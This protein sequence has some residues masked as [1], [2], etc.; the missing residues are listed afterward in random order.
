MRLMKVSSLVAEAQAILAQK[1]M[2]DG[3]YYCYRCFDCARLI[4][5]IEVI[6]ARGRGDLALCRCGSRKVKPT[7]PTVW[8][9]LFLPRCWKLI[10]AIHTQKI[11]LM[12]LP[13]S[14]E[15]QTDAERVARA[16]LRAFEEQLLEQAKNV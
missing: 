2:S 10:Y 1:R 12:P 8:E 6:E 4:T 3:L 13:P 11:S 15:Q 7:N 16:A 9:E 5:K 14:V